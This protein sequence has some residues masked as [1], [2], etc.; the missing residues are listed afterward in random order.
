MTSQR[1]HTNAY[2]GSWRWRTH[3]HISTRNG[4]R[5]ARDALPFRISDT[6]DILQV[7]QYGMN[8]I[9]FES[10]PAAFA[11]LVD[12]AKRDL[13]YRGM[14]DD[15]IACFVWKQDANFFIVRTR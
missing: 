7:A 1:F 12:V 14:R 10:T 4:C 9:L 13:Q 5:F 15:R 6:G 3:D 11:Y 2:C 8:E